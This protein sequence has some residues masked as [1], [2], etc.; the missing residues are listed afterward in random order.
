MQPVTYAL[1]D[2]LVVDDSA[3]S[4]CAST[5]KVHL[6]GGQTAGCHPAMMRPDKMRPRN[7]FLPVAMMAMVAKFIKWHQHL[8]K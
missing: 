4:V 6:D 7:S 8:L 2:V 3:E 1:L 5:L